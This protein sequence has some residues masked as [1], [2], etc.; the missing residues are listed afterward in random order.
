MGLSQETR[1]NIR[2]ASFLPC[3]V[4]AA[5]GIV[6]GI[7]YALCPQAMQGG[8]I[9]LPTQKAGLFLVRLAGALTDNAGFFFAASFAAAF[10]RRDKT[11]GA[12]YGIGA[13]LAVTA[14]ASHYLIHTL[15]PSL[16]LSEL[17]FRYLPSPFTG[18]LAGLAGAYACNKSRTFSSGILYLLAVSAVLSILISGVWFVVFSAAVRLGSYL[19]QG[20]TA[21][22]CA[23]AGLNRL[24]M[25]LNLHHG[26]NQ[27]VLF[28]EGT[29]DL[30]RYWA[31]C[32]EGDPGRFMCGFFAP[33]MF[34]IP[35]V[36]LAF[37][38][39]QK[40]S[41]ELKRFLIMAAVSS[42]ICGFSEP[43][44]FFLLFTSPLLYM[45]YCLL[46]ILL[47]LPAVLFDFRSGFAL[48]GGLC[49]LFFSAAFPA[50]AKTWMILPLGII[51]FV[52]YYAVSVKLLKK[53]NIESR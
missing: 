45:Q 49:D 33:M 29:G 12:L 25:P 44:E 17:T 51:A 48:S 30:V 50:A 16:E 40:G 19:A 13:W 27:S 32:T 41:E 52:V 47:A 7:G 3:A 11:E 9:I 42:F 23:Y 1:S 24:L 28:Q 4:M 53:S 14:L 37:H 26:L 38:K 21:A 18:V 8:T 6:L 10:S 46:Y 5:S 20:G 36:A 34:G 31:N 39:T 35:A 22:V 2:K 15:F 43:M